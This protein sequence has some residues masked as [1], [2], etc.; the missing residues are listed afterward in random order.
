MINHLFSPCQSLAAMLLLVAMFALGIH[1]A[2]AAAQGPK[3]AELEDTEVV[4]P[5]VFDT[6]VVLVKIDVARLSL[7]DLEK[8]FP[9]ASSD[10][11]GATKEV[12]Q[13]LQAGLDLLRTMVAQ[14]PIYVSASLP[15]SG[16]QIPVFVFVRRTRELDA[17]RLMH[18]L[19]REMRIKATVRDDYIVTNPFTESNV[20]A[21][22]QSFTPT[23]REHMEVAFQSVNEFPVQVL[24]LPP[25]YLRRTL[26]ELPVELPEEVGGGSSQLLVD[27]IT[28]AA[29]GL[30][31]EKLKAKLVVESA[32][33]EAAQQLADRLPRMTQAALAMMP[34]EVPDEVRQQV[35][36]L[37]LGSLES[38][39]QGDRIQLDLEGSEQSAAAMTILTAA[40]RMI[41]QE[42]QRG[43]NET[44][45]K[46]IL[47]AMH[48]YHEIFKSF[49][50]AKPHRQE[51][52]SPHLS[53]RV[54][55]LPFLEQQALYEQFRLDEPWDSPHNRK[56]IDIMPEVYQSHIAGSLLDGKVKPGHTT[57]LAPVGKGT[58][59]GQDEA[60]SFRSFRDGT[61]NSIVLVEA[62]PERA[63]PWTAPQ[64]YQFDPQRPLEGVFVGSGG[65]WLGAL[66]DGSVH[67][68][69]AELSVETV[70]RLFQIDDGK[71]VSLDR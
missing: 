59:F 5:F 56:L 31:P 63:V 66:A 29:L 49:P 1:S 27:G 57:F 6:T 65:F 51:D 20:E 24:L 42:T 67:Q 32:S 33:S 47:L 46:Q 64:D 28:W 23:P 22:L 36:Q 69:S 44:R 62:K 58:A 39:V 70:L 4:R 15:I 16:R 35:G 9:P 14:Q 68:L 34:R 19:D 10:A 43:V 3:T 48:N 38:H 7:P 25:D 53:W 8:M 13:R 60:V 45:F 55:L 61:S 40:A 18:F 50:P 71:P 11:A 21:S 37:V 12:T 52:G 30:A 2:P 17:D 26:E 41:R 54:Y